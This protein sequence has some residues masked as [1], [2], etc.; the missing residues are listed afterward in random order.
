MLGQI[1]AAL[2]HVWTIILAYQFSGFIGAVLSFFLPV[3]SEI[4]WAVVIWKRVGPLNLY[5]LAIVAVV[6][7]FV[8]GGLLVQLAER[9][10]LNSVK[11]GGG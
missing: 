11:K 3:I 10:M 2:L 8:I 7:L 1:G 9:A 6:A 5:M 4:W